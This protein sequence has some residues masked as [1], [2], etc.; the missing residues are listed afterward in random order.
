[1]R[2]SVHIEGFKHANPIPNASRIGNIV[3]SGVI[4]GRDPVT[5]KPAETLEE[6][7]AFIGSVD[8]TNRKATLDM[9]G[10]TG[11]KEFLIQQFDQKIASANG[12]TISTI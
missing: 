3:M 6:Q 2:K 12:F 8:D 11:R 10:A 1:M 9:Q 5:E 4:L 7:C